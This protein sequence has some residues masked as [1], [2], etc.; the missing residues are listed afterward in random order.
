VESLVT[1]P[2]TGR[3]PSRG[4]GGHFPW[5][6]QILLELKAHK[7]IHDAHLAQVMNYL[8]ATGLVLGYVINFGH[9]EKLQWKRV[10]MSDNLVERE[11]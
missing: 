10:L 9:P 1:M 2:W 7:E 3:S 4:L 5:N 11:L 6:T 8:K